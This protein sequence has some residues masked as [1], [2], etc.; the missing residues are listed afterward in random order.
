MTNLSFICLSFDQLSLRQL[1]DVLALR[2]DVF[3]VEQNCPFHDTDGKDFVAHHCLGYDSEGDLVAYTRLFDADLS[4]EGYVSIGRVATARKVRG[5]G[6]GQELL[7]FSLQKCVEL[8]SPK[9]IK[10][11]AQKYLL[12]F[13]ESFGFVSTGHDYLEDGIPH[14][15]MIR[16]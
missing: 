8:Y 4:F 15:I 11:G 12:K 10:I 14:A 5:Q 16:P 9:P 3:I 7:R 2:T 1:Y 6:L 13:Y